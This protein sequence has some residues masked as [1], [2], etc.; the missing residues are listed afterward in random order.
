M[1]G[2]QMTH[3]LYGNNS[4][5]PHDAVLDDDSLHHQLEQLLALF[6]G[7]AVDVRSDLG[8]ECVQVGYARLAVLF[9]LLAPL[10][11]SDCALE[12]H[13]ALTQFCHLSLVPSQFHGPVSIGVRDAVFL[14]GDALEG[15]ANLL[16]LSL[17]RLFCAR[18]GKP[19]FV[20]LAS[21][22]WAFD[23]VRHCHPYRGFQRIGLYRTRR[24]LLAR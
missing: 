8:T 11:P 20:L 24:A 10:N 12:L 9:T 14:V 6:E 15:D 13:A 2:T 21:P 3:R 22:L 16:A 19:A 7:E 18:C 5:H 1:S 4:L 23:C 17:Q